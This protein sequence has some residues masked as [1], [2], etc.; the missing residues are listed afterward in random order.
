MQF[1]HE[2]CY[3]GPIGGPNYRMFTTLEF[4][5]FSTCK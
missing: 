1:K 2:F 3:D 4:G 5:I